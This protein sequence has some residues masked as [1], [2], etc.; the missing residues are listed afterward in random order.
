MFD[1]T[2]G[3]Q[4]VCKNSSAFLVG[5]GHKVI[6]IKLSRDTLN[7]EPLNELEH[8]NFLNDTNIPIDHF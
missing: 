3:V 4:N 5:H 2:T 7:F 8:T 1:R 6:L